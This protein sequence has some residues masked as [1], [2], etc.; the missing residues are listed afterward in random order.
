[1]NREDMGKSKVS[2]IEQFLVIAEKPV[3]W[4]GSPAQY[5][6]MWSE[7]KQMLSLRLKEVKNLTTKNIFD[8]FSLFENYIFRTSWTLFG[9]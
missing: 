4:E 1:M 2:D 8:R 5:A 6:T 7:L 9:Y 3:T